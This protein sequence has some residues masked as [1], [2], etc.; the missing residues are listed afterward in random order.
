MV[1]W[2][3][4]LNDR[5]NE[6]KWKFE[7]SSIRIKYWWNENCDWA[8]F[9]V[10]AAVGLGVWLIKHAVG[11]TDKVIKQAMSNR[12]LAREQALKDLYVYDRSAGHYWKLTRKLTSNEWLQI[13]NRR[14]SGEKIGAILS[15]MKVI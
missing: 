11:S 13:E 2:K 12:L 14:K 15:S 9:V 4:K 7:Q 1:T 3:N 6:L 8:V 10:P 5:K